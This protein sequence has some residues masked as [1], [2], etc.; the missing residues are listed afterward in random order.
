MKKS[1]L[2]RYFYYEEYFYKDQTNFAL[3]RLPLL[4]YNGVW[5]GMSKIPQSSIIKGEN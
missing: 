5:C 2:W 1:V 4:C 3:P